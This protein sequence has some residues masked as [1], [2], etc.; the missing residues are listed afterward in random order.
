MSRRRNAPKKKRTDGALHDDNSPD[1]SRRSFLRK[2]LIGGGVV[3]LCMLGDSSPVQEVR[4]D[5][6]KINRWD[7]LEDVV[8]YEGNSHDTASLPDIVRQKYILLGPPVEIGGDTVSDK[9][10][11]RTKELS[12]A[13]IQR[14]RLT[15]DY[16]LF[17]REH[18]FGVPAQPQHAKHLLEY[19]R[20]AVDHARNRLKGFD[21]PDI[22]W[23]VLEPGQDFSK[24]YK[25]RGYIGHSYYALRTPVM[26][27]KKDPKV[28]IHLKGWAEHSKGAFVE[29][30][31]GATMDDWHMFISVG[32]DAIISPIS[33]AVPLII[34][35]QDVA[36]K[37]SH[38]Y[39]L[40]RQVGEA[41][42]E[43]TSRKLS[44]E[45]VQEIP[46]PGGFS[47]IENV[48]RNMSKN[49]LYKYV[50]AAERW[51]DAQGRNG[52]RKALEMYMKDPMD[53]FAAIKRYQ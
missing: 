50:P 13:E 5:P 7:F 44:R 16:N 6:V 42:S 17:I 31:Y 14:R 39:V 43:G 18:I 48:N 32:P 24:D 45:L 20:R 30:T 29:H 10:R 47:K 8:D 4:P 40:A 53:F 38:G 9:D 12:D 37:S 1:P 19:S 3:A 15:R 33:E 11:K 23:T 21:I 22:R 41:L 51:M 26:R 25:H 2:V 46:I 49:W 28:E 36:L 35:N 27:D 52:P 34:V